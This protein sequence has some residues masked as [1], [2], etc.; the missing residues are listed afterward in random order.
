M[1]LLVHT[2]GLQ[3]K[4]TRAFAQNRQEKTPS[5]TRE[6]DIYLHWEVKQ[7]LSGDLGHGLRTGLCTSL[8]HLS[9]AV[10]QTQLKPLL[11]FSRPDAHTHTHTLTSSAWKSL[12]LY[13]IKKKCLRRTLTHNSEAA[14]LVS[15]TLRAGDGLSQS[16]SLVALRLW[17]TKNL[18]VQ[19][20]LSTGH[21]PISASFNFTFS[22]Q[23]L[24]EKQT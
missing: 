22:L 18:I 2:Y 12:S 7:S 4:W 9:L 6:Y 16:C 24:T 13:I 10:Q 3:P 15:V 20:V 11:W 19:R 21:E 23:T 8:M 5:S 1:C 17:D 14:D